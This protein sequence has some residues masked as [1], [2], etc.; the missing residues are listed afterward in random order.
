MRAAIREAVET[1]ALA[2]FLVL[3]LQATVQNYLV[4]GSSMEPLLESRDR[5]LVNKTV[6]AEVDAHRAARF[7]PGVDAEEVE[8]WTPLQP[9]QPGDVV[10]FRSPLPGD[11][12]N[13]VKRIIAEPGD[14]VRIENGIVFLNGIRVGEEWVTRPKRETLRER[15]VPL[16]HYYLLGDNRANSRDSRDALIGTISRENIIG[17]VALVYWP[18]GHFRAM[19]AGPR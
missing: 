13:F 1:I 9:P 5:V 4:E 6:Y 14:R 11:T 2:V 12:S 3:V 8:S 10:V 7:I 17:K 15:I 16:D 18:V 19:F